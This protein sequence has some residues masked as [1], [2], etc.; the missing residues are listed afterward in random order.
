M[1]IILITS[2]ARNKREMSDE[3]GEAAMEGDTPRPYGSISLN[4]AG[5][6]SDYARGVLPGS[7]SSMAG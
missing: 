4:S 1:G 7:A 5:W 3:K 2:T 6:Y